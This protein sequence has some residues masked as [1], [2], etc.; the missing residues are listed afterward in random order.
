MVARPDLT[1]DSPRVAEF[2][3]RRTRTDLMEALFRSRPQT[4][5]GVRELID[6][7][8]L[9]GWRSRVSDARQRLVRAQVGDIEWNRQPQRSAYRFVPQGV[10]PRRQE[11]GRFGE[12]HRR[13]RAAVRSARQGS[14]FPLPS[15]NQGRG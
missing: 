6:V 1:P 7:G 3:R 13:T 8:G 5:I 9:L 14:L 10:T 15:E 11:E 12:P 2:N 4:W